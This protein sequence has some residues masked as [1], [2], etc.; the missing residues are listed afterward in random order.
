[1]SKVACVKKSRL[2]PDPEGPR[3]VESDWCLISSSLARSYVAHWGEPTI[4]AERTRFCKA[5]KK[6]A[7]AQEE[8]IHFHW[9]ID[10]DIVW[11][12]DSGRRKTKK[13]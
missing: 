1:M 4:F 11:G 10:W 3:Q 12:P 9:G 13:E 2:L 5:C 6:H 7:E 8:V